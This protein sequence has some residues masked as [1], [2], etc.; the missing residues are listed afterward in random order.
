MLIN[1]NR[2]L[3]SFRLKENRLNSKKARL[4]KNLILNGGFKPLD[5]LD[6]RI[7]PQKFNPELVMEVIVNINFNKEVCC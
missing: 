2:S 6:E 7:F 3:N 1:D 4:I 5:L